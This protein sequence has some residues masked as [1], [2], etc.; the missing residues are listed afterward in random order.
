MQSEQKLCCSHFNKL[1][2]VR[3]VTAEGHR[4]TLS[5]NHHKRQVVRLIVP[6]GQRANKASWLC[7]TPDLCCR[8]C[9]IWHGTDG[10]MRTISC[11]NS[12]EKCKIFFWNGETKTEGVTWGRERAASGREVRTR[13]LAQQP[14][15]QWSQSVLLKRGPL[16]FQSVGCNS[17]RNSIPKHYQS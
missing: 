2:S 17:I 1:I 16:S 7:N 14:D 11:R 4:T 15:R 10:N 8:L 9:F 5:F 6:K 3:W 12:Q 13:Q